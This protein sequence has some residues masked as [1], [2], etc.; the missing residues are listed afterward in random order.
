MLERILEDTRQ[1]LRDKVAYEGCERLE[2]RSM[3][4]SIVKARKNPI[5]AEIKRRSPSHGVLRTDFDV[6]ELARM[7][8]RGGAVSIS[9]LTEPKHFGGDMRYIPEVKKAVNL[10]VL[11]KDFIIDERQLMDA[12]RAGADAALL[13]VRVLGERI[14]E[15]LEICRNLGIEPLV[16]VHSRE[17]VEIAVSAGSGLIGI[18]NRDLETLKVDLSRTERLIQYIPSGVLVVSESGISTPDDVRRVI[19]AGADAVLV[20]TAIMLSQNVEQKVREL[21]ES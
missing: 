10:P 6:A 16:E 11:C 15:M 7:M 4:R 2:R 14:H 21:V 20:G 3:I 9:V 18:N 12:A 8:E 13:I 1:R 19:R 5:I 17:D